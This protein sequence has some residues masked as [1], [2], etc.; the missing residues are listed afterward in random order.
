[1][2]N[3]SKKLKLGDVTLEA[4]SQDATAPKWFNDNISFGSDNRQIPL[5][6]VLVGFRI[7]FEHEHWVNKYAV[8]L[9]KRSNEVA[10]AGC[11]CH[12][13]I[14]LQTHPGV[15]HQWG[16]VK[17]RWI[18]PSER[19]RDL[20][21]K[22]VYR[23]SL[24]HMHQ[25]DTSTWDKKYKFLGFHVSRE[26]QR[27]GMEFLMSQV[28]QPFN[29]KGYLL[30]LLLPVG[31]GADFFS[32]DLMNKNNTAEWYCT[33]II[34]A[35]LQ[36]MAECEG[37]LRDEVIVTSPPIGAAYY[38]AFMYALV[39]SV[40]ACIIAL[41][42]TREIVLPL[43][44]LGSVFGG[45]FVP[46]SLTARLKWNASLTRRNKIIAELKKKS[47]RLRK[48]CCRN[49]DVIPEEASVD[50][51]DRY[52]WK[53]AVTKTV[54]TWTN[55]NDLWRTLRACEDVYVTPH[56]GAPS[57]DLSVDYDIKDRKPSKKQ[58]ATNTTTPWWRFWK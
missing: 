51:V 2:S 46:I 10:P 52:S 35:A 8:W 50:D 54:G 57:L 36:A 6:F 40:L 23:W 19:P 34:V 7:H 31:V 20:K 38:L 55:P 53:D 47:S 24:V 30:N 33:Q 21:A 28:N 27:A 37:R 41:L 22:E 25:V 44:V 56:P 14:M 12:A 5:T 42:S 45:V 1:M 43:I 17:K 32:E 13:E 11:M 29:F 39:I 18:D 49:R 3:V 48:V 58:R 4:L 9:T 16:V 15:W 26:A